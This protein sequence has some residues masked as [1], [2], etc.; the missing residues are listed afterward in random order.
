[1]RTNDN[2]YPTGNSR[3]N[4]TETRQPSEAGEPHSNINNLDG[5]MA[6]KPSQVVEE[7]SLTSD[8]Q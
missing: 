5:L 6:R 8:S 2:G 4:G 3:W 1:M 7:A